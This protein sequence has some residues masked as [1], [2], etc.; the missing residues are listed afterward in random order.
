MQGDGGKIGEWFRTMVASLIGGAIAFGA[1]WYATN[2]AADAQNRAELRGKYEL[3]TMSVLDAYACVTKS[4]DAIG[5]DMDCR[6]GTAIEK[7]HALQIT[8]F[9]DLDSA[10]VQYFNSYRAVMLAI[11][12]CGETVVDEPFENELAEMRMLDGIPREEAATSDIERRAIS[13]LK[14][15]SELQLRAEHVEKILQCRLEAVNRFKPP[16]HLTSF[17]SSARIIETKILVP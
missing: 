7:A 9:P 11:K 8:Y 17:M 16:D 2:R 12:D 14:K 13:R 5:I 1:T 6:V 10:F 3:L 4:A 15:W